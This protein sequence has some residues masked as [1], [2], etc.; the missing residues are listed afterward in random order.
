MPQLI[1]LF[2]EAL[3]TLTLAALMKSVPKVL[4]NGIVHYVDQ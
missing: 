1:F 4:Q 2:V 3:P